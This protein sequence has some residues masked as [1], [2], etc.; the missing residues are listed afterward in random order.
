MSNIVS[1]RIHVPEKFTKD[2]VEA[3]MQD[4]FFCETFPKK[5]LRNF[6]HEEVLKGIRLTFRKGN[7]G[8]KTR[9]MRDLNDD[10]PSFG[11]YCDAS[12]AMDILQFAKYK[13]LVYG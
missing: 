5:S 1:I 3:A 9:L 10:D 6:T 4:Q 2:I 7:N 12:D 8:L 11:G 13:E